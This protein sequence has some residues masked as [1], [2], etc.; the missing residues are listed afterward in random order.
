MISA[1]KHLPWRLEVTLLRVKTGYV[2]GGT[3]KV[4]LG[5]KSDLNLIAVYNLPPNAFFEH[6]LQHPVFLVPGQL[7]QIKLR[8]WRMA[9]VV[10]VRYGRDRS[11]GYRGIVLPYSTDGGMPI[12]LRG[13]KNLLHATLSHKEEKATL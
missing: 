9:E 11:V 4:L 2:K 13:D 1:S 6:S 7:L 12:G 3:Y 5:F 8:S 10:E